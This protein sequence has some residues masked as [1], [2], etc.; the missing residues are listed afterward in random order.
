MFLLRLS[1]MVERQLVTALD[2]LGIVAPEKM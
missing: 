2:L 1:R